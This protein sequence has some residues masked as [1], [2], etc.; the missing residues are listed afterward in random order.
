MPELRTPIIEC[1]RLEL[2]ISRVTSLAVA[3]SRILPHIQPQDRTTDSR[4]MVE[5][6]FKQAV[7]FIVRQAP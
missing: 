1:N 7:A 3:Y 2:K 5:F 6:L 4:D